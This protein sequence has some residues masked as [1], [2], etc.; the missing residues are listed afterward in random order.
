M[1]DENSACVG[2]AVCKCS[3]SS[4]TTMSCQT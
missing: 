4:S 3:V 1:E 2:C